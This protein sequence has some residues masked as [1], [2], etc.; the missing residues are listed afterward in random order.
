MRQTVA[1]TDRLGRAPFVLSGLL[2]IDAIVATLASLAR[3]D[4]IHG[5]AASIGSLRG[6]AL[7]VLVVGVPLLAASMALVRRGS[8]L[9]LLGW[10]GVLAYISY[11]GVLFLFGSPFNGLFFGYLGILSFGVWALIALVPRLPVGDIAA[12]FGPRTPTRLVAGYLVVVAGLFYVLWLRA[13][14]PA[15][16]DST[17]PGFLEGTGM[18]TGPGQILDLGFALPV[19]VIAAVQLWQRRPWGY[20]LAGAMLT[21]L[22]IETISIGVDQWFGSDADPTSSAVS[23]AMIPVFAGLSVVDLVVLAAYL[24]DVRLGATQRHLRVVGAAR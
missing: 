13:I 14:V 20:L 12:R 7:V 9:A 16:F 19:G 21:M 24:R 8:L 6:T 3:P 22:A 2:A 5:P 11:Q 1:P 10:L 17:S 18:T 23:A 15:L 4:L